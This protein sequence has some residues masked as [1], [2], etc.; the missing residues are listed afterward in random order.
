MSKAATEE[1]KE[2]SGQYE[3]RTIG[4]NKYGQQLNG[5]TR[6]VKR[7]ETVKHIKRKA[8]NAIHTMYRGAT[9][10]VHEDGDIS[11]GGY[12]ANGQLGVGTYDA[13]ITT[14]HHLDFK[15]KLVSKGILSRHVFVIKAK[16]G[17]LYSV[18]SNDNNQ[19]GIQTGS[20]KIN[21][22]MAVPLMKISIQ[23]IATGFSFTIFLG[24]NGSMHACGKSDD[25]ALGMG[26]KKKEVS[27]PTVIPTTTKMAQIAMGWRHC[28]AISKEQSTAFSWGSNAYGQCGHGQSNDSIWEPTRIEC[29]RNKSIKQVDCGWQH[30]LLVG[31]DGV[32]FTTGYNGNGQCGDGTTRDIFEPKRIRVGENEKVESIKCGAYHNVLTT[33]TNKIF[34]WGLNDYNQCLVNDDKGNVLTPTLY[35]I[36]EMFK[37]R[38]VQVIPGY[39][40][41]RIIAVCPEIVRFLLGLGLERYV[42]AFRE[43]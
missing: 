33:T 20:D 31:S 38:D 9:V 24:T 39:R 27:T 40:S 12:N 2:E 14:I 32:L 21:T 19:C 8:I 42:D 41:T 43:E 23:S 30:T 34:V 6:D 17:K 5:T 11:V 18:G 29:L 4:W 10:I 13:A 36:P 35:T 28:V 22:W 15:V 3:M 1:T 25:G 37:H 16:D 26:S 7:L